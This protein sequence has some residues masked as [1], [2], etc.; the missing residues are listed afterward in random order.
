MGDPPSHAVDC[1]PSR[2]SIARRR[3]RHRAYDN[4][5]LCSYQAHPLA[6]LLVNTKPVAV[7]GAARR[8]LEEVAIISGHI[9]FNRCNMAA[10]LGKWILWLVA[11][12]VAVAFTAGGAYYLTR[13]SASPEPVAQ[14]GN[15][16][17]PAEEIR[18]EVTRPLKGAMPR[19]SSGPGSVQSFEWADLVA[20]A[21][22]YLKTQTVDI[23]DRVIEGQVLATLDVPDLDKQVQHQQAAV[24]AAQAHVAQMEAHVVSAKADVEAAKAEIVRANAAI[25]ST[26]AKAVFRGK[27]FDR[28]YALYHAKEGAA[29]DERL[30]DEHQDDRDAA[31]AAEGE[32]HADLAKANAM[33]AAANAKVLSAQADVVDAQADVK[34]AQAE[35]EKAQVMVQFATITSPYTGVITYRTYS[36]AIT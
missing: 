6:R 16:P 18:V 23:G 13:S 21:S 15:E 33:V 14:D 1:R 12:A 35:L 5:L 2:L 24:E 32:A 36:Q 7:L 29:I 25:D 34:V 8:L 19:I 3:K 4:D 22:G 20:G 31:R 9:D 30:V 26:H 27:Q 10:L 11:A 17:S 28:M